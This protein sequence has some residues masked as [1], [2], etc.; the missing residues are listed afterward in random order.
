MGKEPGENLGGIEGWRGV[1]E[2]GGENGR[3]GNWAQMDGRSRKD[4]VAEERRGY[5][6]K[7]KMNGHRSGNDRLTR[8]VEGRVWGRHVVEGRGEKE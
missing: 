4:G 7:G 5:G 1:V 2:A 6:W 3:I 8:A